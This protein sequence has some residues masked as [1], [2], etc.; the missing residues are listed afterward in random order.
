MGSELQKREETAIEFVQRCGGELARVLPKHMTADRMTRLALSALRTNKNL[1][2]CSVQSVAV[3][4]MACSVL[5]LEPNTP[6]GH[7]YLIPFKKECTFVIGYKGM[8]ELFYR[9]GA[10]ASAQSFSVFD[11]DEFRVE[12]GLNR[13][14][15]HVPSNNP[16]RCDPEKLTHVYAV[17]EL[18]EHGIKPIWGVLDR[19]QVEQHRARSMARDSGPWKSDYVKMAEKTAIRD[20]ARF[21]PFSIE[22]VSAAAAY[23]GARERGQM[24]VAISALGDEAYDLTHQL[25]GDIE[26]S[27]PA[28]EDRGL[29][30]ITEKL[31]SRATTEPEAGPPTPI[32]LSV[33]HGIPVDDRLVP[34]PK[35]SVRDEAK[36][37]LLERCSMAATELWGD[38]SMSQ[39]TRYARSLSSPIIAVTAATVEELKILL[40]SL[41][42]EIDKQ[43]GG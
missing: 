12:L 31:K 9:S 36:Q 21:V 32:T 38:N 17:I 27:Q 34:P 14:L 6:Q 41:N 26:D 3:S 24:T 42:L 25:V 13:N 10:V 22:R 29:D 40:S 43:V 20:I 23:E 7:A 2:Q 28:A 5:G 35:H 33:P 8:I 37:S 1:A 11:G 15:T 16:T 30:A 18:K 39:L 4:L 19:Y